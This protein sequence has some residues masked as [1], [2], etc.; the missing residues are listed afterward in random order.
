MAGVKCDKYSRSTERSW[1]RV[2]R[3]ARTR[4]RHAPV[5]GAWGW[6]GSASGRGGRG[7]HRWRKK[8]V[9]QVDGMA[10][11]AQPPGCAPTQSTPTP[12]GPG[13]STP[14]SPGAFRFTPGSMERSRHSPSGSD[15]HGALIAPAPPSSPRRAPDPFPS[16]TNGRSRLIEIFILYIKLL[17]YLTHPSSRAGSEALC[18]H[19]LPNAR[20][21]HRLAA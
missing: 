10:K 14:P 13:H 16:L 8:V 12:P 3:R 7:G 20:C 9:G 1:G 18:A 4:S 5:R 19:F 2:S 17:I 15:K 21:R 11:T 6:R